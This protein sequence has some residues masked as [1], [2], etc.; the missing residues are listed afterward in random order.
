MVVSHYRSRRAPTGAIYKK[1][2]G[3]RLAE[4]GNEPTLTKV[5]STRSKTLRTRGADVKRRLLSHDTVNLYNP[6]TK[7]H[8][9]AKI[10]RVVESPADIN[11]VRR[12]IV[13]KGTVVKTDKGNAKVTSRPGQEGSIN[14]VLVE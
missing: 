11:Y 3:R 6:K 1:Y 7:K 12:N 13:V 9:Q 5:G 14:A 8:E 2:R 4:L 10:E